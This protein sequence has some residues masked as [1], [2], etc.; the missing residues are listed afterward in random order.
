MNIYFS[1]PTR[2]SAIK[3]TKDNIEDLVKELDTELSFND[4]GFYIVKSEDDSLHS[5]TEE[6]F[7]ELFSI[8]N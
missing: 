8:V 4:I 1:K 2:V 6:L 7:N 5:Y 3:L